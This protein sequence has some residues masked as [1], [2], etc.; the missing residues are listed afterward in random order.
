MTNQ[1]N[2]MRHTFKRTLTSALVSSVSLAMF[3]GI[4]AAQETYQL[5]EVLVTATKRESSLQDVAV[6]VSAL[7]SAMLEGNQIVR[8]EDLTNLI[9]S[10]TVQAGG[11]PRSSSFNIRGVGTQS[12]SSG[13][14]PSVSTMVDGV[15]MGRSAMAFT[16]LP[17]IQRVEVLRGPQGTLFGKNA[18][19]GLIHIITKDPSQ[20]HEGEVSVMAV[21]QDEYRVSGTVSGPITDSIG[22]RLT[23]SY[24]DDEGYIENVYDGED[25]NSHEDKLLRAKIAW[26]ATESLY[27]KY[28][29]DW[30]DN[31]C[32]CQV[33]PLREA[34]GAGAA[35]LLPVV[36]SDE[37]DKINT[38]QTPNSTSEST[39]HVLDV[40]WEVGDHTITSISAYRDWE[41][42]NS[43][44]IGFLPV[45]PLSLV[46]TGNSDQDQFS[47]EL[48]LTSPVDQFA[49]YVVGLYYFEQTVDRHFDRV[50]QLPAPN[51]TLI[52]TA[53]DFTVESTNYA[54]FGE[55]VFNLTDT[56]RLIAGGRLTDD[57]LEYS[58]FTREGGGKPVNPPGAGD[59]TSETNF[60]GKAA[61]QW[62]F[63]DTAMT[64]IS[65]AQ[66]YKGP[67]FSLSGNTDVTNLDSVDPETSDAWEIGLK[68]NFFDNTMILN[69]AIFTTEY[70]DFQSESFVDDGSG[71]GT[72]EFRLSNAGQVTTEGVEVDLTWRPVANL[73]LFTGVA[74]IDAQIDDY[75]K[76]PCSFGQTATANAEY[77]ATGVE[78]LECADAANMGN[79]SQDLSGDD[80]PNSPDWRVTFNANYLIP[81]ESMPFGLVLNGNYR[82]Q[83]DVLFSMAQD[84][85]TIQDSYAIL[86]MSIELRDD[87][88]RYSITAFVKNATD[89]FY[90]SAINSAHPASLPGGGYSQLVP[91]TAERTLGAEVKYRW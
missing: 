34:N 10:L 14:E 33:Q 19:S 13:V 46:Q 78:N 64:Y 82:W 27:L 29:V 38:S 86:D 89:E 16:Q 66:G 87:D 6:A 9:P 31:D 32:H 57:E 45:D 71:D 43:A 83:D 2:R 69:V 20:E 49:S 4:T 40:N 26:D 12:F 88:E 68:S 28:T 73:T 1:G 7:S 22:F 76:G 51:N 8:S 30:Q 42:E 44:G 56:V 84:E 50:I 70:Q 39:G 59:D 23:G 52:T 3:S 62:D 75:D 60:S 37:N 91:K 25:Y 79:S 17:D 65:F 85:G 15:V 36:A 11:N 55:A 48:R 53:T 18:S 54:A 77:Q 47:Q 81:L 61:L 58:D 72:G 63:S 41:F 90:V 67:A 80:L 35:A 24:I 21:E 74:Y 5:E